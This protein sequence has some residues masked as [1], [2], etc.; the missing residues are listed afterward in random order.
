M[1]YIQDTGWEGIGELQRRYNMIPGITIQGNIIFMEQ[2]SQCDEADNR[3]DI[4]FKFI[5]PDAA[6]LAAPHKRLDTDR[7]DKETWKF[8]GP[9]SLAVWESLQTNAR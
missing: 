2:V 8:E 6:T 5:A 3:K 4:L 7:K 1:T 9:M